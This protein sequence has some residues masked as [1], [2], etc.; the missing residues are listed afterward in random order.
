MSTARDDTVPTARTVG[1]IAAELGVPVHRVTYVLRTR[2]EIR[3]IARAGHARVYDAAAVDAVR[4][5]LRRIEAAR[6][7]DAATA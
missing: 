2:P 7:R 5:A 4:R 6:H 1:R 3:P